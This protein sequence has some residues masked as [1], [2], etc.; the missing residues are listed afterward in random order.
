MG[1]I[2]KDR[3]LLKK[4]IRSNFEEGNNTLDWDEAWIPILPNFKTNSAKPENFEVFKVVDLISVDDRSWNIH[5][6]HQLFN[7]EEIDVILKIPIAPQGCLDRL[8][9]HHDRKGVYS[10]T[11]EYKVQKS[12]ESSL[13]E[14]H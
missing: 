9:W 14:F 11:S 7:D 4:G 3:D 5:L 1:S 2:L 8:V 10:V 13:S 12:I 6:L